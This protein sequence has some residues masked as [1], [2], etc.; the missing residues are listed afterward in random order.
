MLSKLCSI[1]NKQPFNKKDLVA[2]MGQLSKMLALIPPN[3]NEDRVRTVY[4]LQKSRSSFE[5]S[6]SIGSFIKNRRLS[7]HTFQQ[8]SC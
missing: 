1:A 4:R 6:K 8:S 5:D 7:N 3:L 2:D